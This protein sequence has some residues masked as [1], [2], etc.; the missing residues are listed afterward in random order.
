MTKSMAVIAVLLAI[1]ACSTSPP[2]PTTDASG[3]ARADPGESNEAP[4]VNLTVV[5]VAASPDESA[6][7]VVCIEETKPGSRIVIGERCHLRS[8]LGM[9]AE[10]RNYIQRELAGRGMS[11]GWKSEDQ[12]QLERGLSQGPQLP[13]Q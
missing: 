1:T 2:A 11:P 10:T 4:P 5:T 9:N 8:T 6:D 12:I 13:A 7:D 3:A